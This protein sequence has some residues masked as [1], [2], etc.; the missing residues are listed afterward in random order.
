MNNSIVPE[1]QSIHN[2]IPEQIQA[3]NSESKQC[4]DIDDDDISEQEVEDIH[5]D[6]LS[7]D[8]V[9]SISL[10][11]NDLLNF[12]KCSKAIFI[13]TRSPICLKDLSSESATKLIKY[14]KEDRNR[15]IGIIII[16][17]TDSKI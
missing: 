8:I 12:E 16:I 17:G 9:A 2:K 10:Q 14:L 5:F 3:S 1:I 13:G 6:D 4:E 15:Q 11:F 7:L